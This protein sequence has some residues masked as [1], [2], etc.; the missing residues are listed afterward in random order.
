DAVVTQRYVQ[1]LEHGLDRIRAT[2]SR[3]ALDNRLVL[4]MHAILLQD[5][6]TRLRA[7]SYRNVQAWIGADRI[8]DASFVPAPPSAIPGCMAELERAM[9]QYA[10]QEDEP[11]ELSV[12]AQVAIAHA[13][14]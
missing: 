4:R 11:W 1:A 14:F 10:P 2:G 12:V 6:P 8:E 7:G 9:L 5:A 13:Q 3:R